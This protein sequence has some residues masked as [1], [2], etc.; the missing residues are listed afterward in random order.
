[1]TALG[2]L[3]HESGPRKKTDAWPLGD[4][5]SLRFSVDENGHTLSI[6]EVAISLPSVAG[7]TSQNFFAV[8][9][10]IE[11]ED[12]CANHPDE[13]IGL[14]LKFEENEEQEA[15]MG[16]DITFHAISQRELEH[17]VFDVL[18]DPSLAGPRAAE[19]TPDPEKQE[20]IKT[21]I[22]Q[23]ALI[24]WFETEKD[25]DGDPIT[26]YN[27][28]Q[29]FAFGIAI[30]AGY[31]HPYWY[32]RNGALRLTRDDH[33]SVGDMFTSYTALP[34]SPFSKFTDAEDVKMLNGNYTGS[35]VITDVKALKLWVNERDSYL[36]QDFESDGYDSLKRIID[37]CLKNDLWFLEA[38]E[39]CIPISDQCNSDF[40]NF[41]A[42]FLNKK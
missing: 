37:Y 35:S 18:R 30:L 36:S 10:A 24:N 6:L 2:L 13:D 8:R 7:Q 40:D 26:N 34:G 5:I 33:P 28:A 31:L 9:K 15:F 17:Y 32:S 20:R 39:V 14:S 1:M 21:S 22:Y 27:F 16:Y 11:V 41:R 42:H 4:T 19:I 12:R 38:T 29:T 3:Q 25:G 23:G